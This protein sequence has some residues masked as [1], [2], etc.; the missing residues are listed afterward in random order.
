MAFPKDMFLAVAYPFLQQ[1]SKGQ[2]PFICCTCHV[3]IPG[4][5]KFFQGSKWFRR[6]LLQ[7][8]AKGLH[9]CLV[10]PEKFWTY[11]FRST[12]ERFLSQLKEWVIT[13]SKILVLLHHTVGPIPDRQTDARQMLGLKKATD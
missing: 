8:N 5:D 10:S 2:L 1:E 3:S 4:S 12:R 6:Q 11:S 13:G 9:L 7:A